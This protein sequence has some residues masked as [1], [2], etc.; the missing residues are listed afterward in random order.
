MFTVREDEGVGCAVNADSTLKDPGQNGFHDT[1]DD[2]PS[3]M[4]QLMPALAS[5]GCAIDMDGQL[6]D[7][8]QIEWFHDPDDD[9]PLNMVQTTS[10][11][12]S[13]ISTDGQ[14]RGISQI[15]SFHGLDDDVPSDNPFPV[16]K[17]TRTP[18]KSS[19]STSQSLNLYLDLEVADDNDNNNENEEEGD[20]RFVI[21]D[22]DLVEDVSSHARRNLEDDGHDGFLAGFK[23]RWVSSH[24]TQKSDDG[25]G[26]IQLGNFHYMEDPI[27]PKEGDWELWEVP[28]RLG[29]EYLTVKRIFEHMFGMLNDPLAS[30]KFWAPWSAFAHKE[31]LGRVYIEAWE[32]ADAIAVSYV[33]C[34]NEKTQYLDIVLVP[35]ICYFPK[36]SPLQLPRS[37]VL[38]ALFNPNKAIATSGSENLFVDDSNTMLTH[39]KYCQEYR[40]TTH[41]Y[42]HYHYC[43]DSS[44]FLLTTVSPAD[45]YHIPVYPLVNEIHLFLNSPVIPLPTK[46]WLFCAAAARELK[47]RDHVKVVGTTHAGSIGVMKALTP[48]HAYVYL[49]GS[50]ETIYLPLNL[51]WRYFKVGDLVCVTSGPDLGY[52]G[53]IVH[54]NEEEFTTTVYDPFC[55]VSFSP[56]Y[57]GYSVNDHLKLKPVTVPILFIQ[58]SFIVPQSGKIPCD[59]NTNVKIAKMQDSRFDH[60]EKLSV[61]I[62]KGPFKGCFGT[63]ISVSQLGI[64]Q[65]EMHTMSIHTSKLQQ[66]KIQSLAPNCML[67]LYVHDQTPFSCSER[68]KD[69]WYQVNKD[70]VPEYTACFVPNFKSL[71]P[72]CNRPKTP[73]LEALRPLDDENSLWVPGAMDKNFPQPLPEWP[74]I[75]EHS[76]LPVM[77]QA[78]LA[79]KS[80]IL[81][82]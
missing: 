81:M 69:E 20:D 27:P 54:I 51:L 76:P 61:I 78:A 29:S 70:N 6:K 77:A 32:W 68:D 5:E 38:P 52:I 39:F 48:T 36:S 64:A 58:F 28:V 57:Q 66:V 25:L 30:M 67:T 46:L 72:S 74:L 33:Q 49:L 82:I 59:P 47:E 79:M 7:T 55:F 3:N 71:L 40:D 56:L 44:G 80:L 23:K 73:E 60:L 35:H 42:Y 4:V 75:H 24:H 13:V 1:N 8:A 65:I 41:C 11:S 31:G 22:Q 21:Y 63:V 45:Y 18:G 2:V 10:A 16:P 62:T 37:R 15:V 17:P 43:F 53:F 26:V 14:L 9:I 12:G 34:V 19:R 50:L